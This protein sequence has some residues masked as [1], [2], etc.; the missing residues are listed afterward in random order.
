[1]SPY[2]WLLLMSICI[3]LPS[4]SSGLAGAL[5]YSAAVSLVW[6]GLGGGDGSG[7][8]A[9]TTQYH[10]FLLRTPNNAHLTHFIAMLLSFAKKI[11]K[12]SYI[13][14][15][16]RVKPSIVR[17]LV[18][19]WMSLSLLL[20]LTLLLF[21]LSF[22]KVFSS[23]TSN[24]LYA[25]SRENLCLPS[26][27]LIIPVTTETPDATL[28]PRQIPIHNLKEAVREMVYCCVTFGRLTV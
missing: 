20:Q 25:C 18:Y 14:R 12:W 8:V 15:N 9:C 10:K 5:K 3:A 22:W 6:W 4:Y 24:N 17:K 11:L 19:L 7:I 23:C 28:L 2:I 1:M 26:I 13:Y 21:L 27:D 16:I